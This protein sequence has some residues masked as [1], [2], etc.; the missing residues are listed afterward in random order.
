LHICDWYGVSCNDE[1]SVVSI[2]L[3]DN[4]IEGTLPS[5]IYALPNLAQLSLFDNPLLTVKFEGIEIASNL[6]ELVL[7]AIG[8]TSLD[9]IGKARS[10]TK[11]AVRNNN[12]AGTLPQDLS[13]LVNI[14][15]LELSNNRFTG[16]IP[17]WLSK[18]PSLSTFLVDGNELTGEIPDFE[19]FE[20]ITLLNISNNNFAG[21]IPETFLTS[22]GQDDKI[23][24]DIS[25]NKLT[26]TLP[27]NLQR[28][29]R[30]GIK[31]DQNKLSAIDPY[32]CTLEAW[33]D[34]DVQEFGC[35]GILC[36]K[37][38]Y[39]DYG[40]QINPETP[41]VPCKAAEY[42]GAAKCS[43]ATRLLAEFGLLALVCF[44]SMFL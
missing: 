17:S 23:F 29:N 27:Y 19:G 30:L 38:T 33:N 12:L 13:R 7:D 22:A 35:A 36:P 15:T 14:E 2:V 20:H 32:L 40:R 8:L 11:L 16:S 41:C 28:L 5:N 34:Y 25:A 39:N 3:G 1:R 42:L 43:G 37:G 10:L 18:I 6:E 24:V 31:A 4:D 9:G 44:G 21:S 26:G